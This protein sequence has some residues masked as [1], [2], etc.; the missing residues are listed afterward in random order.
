LQLED[1]ATTTPGWYD[2]KQIAQQLGTVSGGGAPAGENETWFDASSLLLL[3][4][5]A[6]DNAK[7]PPAT[8]DSMSSL[9]H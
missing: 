5:A 6:L 4:A 1:Q 3:V 7:V 8:P 9:L 2:S